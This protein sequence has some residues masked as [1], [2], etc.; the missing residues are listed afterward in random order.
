MQCGFL[1]FSNVDRT[2]TRSENSK[3]KVNAAVSMLG[4][5]GV[6]VAFI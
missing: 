6:F 4:A 3:I 5:V 1:S 2:G